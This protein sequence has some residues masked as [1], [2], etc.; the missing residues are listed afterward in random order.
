MGFWDELFLS[1]DER[2]LRRLR[3]ERERY[4]AERANAE[5]RRALAEAEAAEALTRI[6]AATRLRAQPLLSGI[7]A[8]R[9]V[10]EAERDLALLRVRGRRDF[11]REAR[12]AFEEETELLLLREVRSLPPEEAA[13][14]LRR[15]MEVEAL[16]LAYGF[17]RATRLGP[18]IGRVGAAPTG[19]ASTTIGS[20]LPGNGASQK[21]LPAAGADAAALQ[22]Y[23]S[24]KAIEQMALKAVARFG[25]LPPGEAE[26]AFSR[27]E[28]EAR[29][30]L[31]EQVADEVVARAAELRG[32]AAD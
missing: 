19:S 4:E 17:A 24:D 26:A 15:E 29:N 12:V 13:A 8:E 16:L 22:P 25:G 30:R 23:Y 21:A 5:A 9:E 1:S 7:A 27:W 31:P 18:G 11:L 28:A 14:R 3:A 6:N 32:L 2:D 10:L 20:G